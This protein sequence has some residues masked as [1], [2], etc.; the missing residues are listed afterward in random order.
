MV[1]VITVSRQ[2]G[3]YG[4]A[5][6]DLI[7]DRLGYRSLD[8]SL[9]LVLAKETGLKPAQVARLSEETYR[10]RGLIERLFA[11][12]GPGTRHPAIWADYGAF[13]A[14]QQPRRRRSRV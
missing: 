4:D 11:D 9:I 3:S 14:G 5:V 10:P 1:S 7:C 2:F 13:V 12:A 8:K 6:V